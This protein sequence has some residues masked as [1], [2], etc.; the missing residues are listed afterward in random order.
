MFFFNVG[1]DI[2]EE[3]GRAAGI[4]WEHLI[5]RASMSS[6]VFRFS[7]CWLLAGRVI[8]LAMVEAVGTTCLYPW[9]FTRNEVP[10]SRASL[11]LANEKPFPLFLSPRPYE[12]FLGYGDRTLD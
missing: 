4:S 5:F 9:A 1:K 3:K 8:T 11:C 10:Q 12:R 7:R 2:S 6:P